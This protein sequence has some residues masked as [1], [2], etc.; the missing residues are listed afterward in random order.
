MFAVF[1]VQFLPKLQFMEESL[2]FCKHFIP[3]I[4][5]Y[6][7]AGRLVQTVL[8]RLGIPSRQN[9]ESINNSC[10][11]GVSFYRKVLKMEITVQ[12]VGFYLQFGCCLVVFRSYQFR[13]S[14][15]NHQRQKM[16]HD[17]VITEITN[18][19]RLILYSSNIIRKK[20]FV[21]MVS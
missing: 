18:P 9:F 13:V 15:L 6:H 21:F 7:N 8:T 12:S 10:L 17:G 1:P 5:L 3:Y 19:V 2:Y 4:I 11:S 16:C 20:A 14:F